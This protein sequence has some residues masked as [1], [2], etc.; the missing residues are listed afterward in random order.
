MKKLF[1]TG[2]IKVIRVNPKT[3]GIWIPPTETKEVLHLVSEA[4][5]VLYTIYR[6]Y[7]FKEAIEIDDESVCDLLDWSTR[8]VQKHRLLLEK[9]D[10]FRLVRYGSITDGI[11]K[12][13]VGSDV[14]TL[15]DAGM[16]AEILEPKALNK[17]KR[18]F[19]I[20]SAKDLIREAN[21]IIMAYETDPERYK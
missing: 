21:N 10:L 11:T 19:N 1:G 17:L 8:K 13:F 9:A 2:D 12:V 5:Y 14:V 15:F 20:E 16:P 7:P 18:E 4:T 3:T 6:T